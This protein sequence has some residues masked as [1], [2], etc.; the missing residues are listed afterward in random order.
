MSRIG[1]DPFARGIVRLTST[2]GYQP[3]R[4]PVL[5]GDINK[6]L[7]HEARDHEIMALE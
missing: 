1:D 6:V 5:H 3:K 4:G 2:S 7:D